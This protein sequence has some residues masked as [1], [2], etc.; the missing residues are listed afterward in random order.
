MAKAA[1]FPRKLEVWVTDAI[2]DGFQLLAQ[3]QLL[4]V[5]DHARQALARYLM[6]MNIP[7]TTPRAANGQQQE[8][9][10]GLFLSAN[11]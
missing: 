2:A 4:S 5:S 6:T 10:N 7:T 8:A 9:R 3:D 1:R 11:S